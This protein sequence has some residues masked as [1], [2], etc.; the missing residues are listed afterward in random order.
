MKPKLQY[1]SMGPAVSELQGKLNGL[2]PEVLPPL[3]P[4]GIFGDKT[5]AR[6]KQFQM[7]R[8][9]VPD[10]VVGAKT[11]AAI[12]GTAP[13]ISKAPLHPSQPP[14]GSWDQVAKFLGVRHGRLLM[15][16]RGLLVGQLRLSDPGRYATVEDCKPFVNIT[17]FGQCKQGILTKSYATS[18]LTNAAFGIGEVVVEEKHCREVCVPQLMEAW[19]LPTKHPQLYDDTGRRLLTV[20]AVVRCDRYCSKT[21]WEYNNRSIGRIRIL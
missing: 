8:G 2:M 13:A 3:K 18:D 16:N 1:L 4:D 6:V 12:D 15:C 9:L 11:W 14:S 5:L 17:P 7:S 19:L 20:G 10:G 21:N